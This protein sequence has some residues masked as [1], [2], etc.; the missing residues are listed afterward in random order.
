MASIGND[1]HRSSCRWAYTVRKNSADQLRSEANQKKQV[2]FLLR[3]KDPLKAKRRRGKNR[4]GKR[5][6]KTVA[7]F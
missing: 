2:L 1:I 6:R 7:H 5:L 4:A 3:R